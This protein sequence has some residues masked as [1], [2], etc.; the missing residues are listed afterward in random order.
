MKNPI[1]F[2]KKFQNPAF[3]LAFL[4]LTFT[5]TPLAISAK[6]D[7]P[8]KQVSQDFTKVAKE[9]IP[10]V[11]S[12]KV[13]YKP[14]QGTTNWQ[15]DSDNAPDVFGDDFLQNFFG[16]LGLTTPQPEIGQASG[17]IVSPD[18]YILT[19]SHVVKDAS[20]IIVTLNDGREFPAKVI[21]QDPN[22]DIA[23]VKINAKNLPHLK[24]GDSDDIEVGQWAIAIGNPFGLQATLTVGVI[25]AK[26]RNNLDLTPLENFIQT[27]AAINKGNSGGPLLNMDGQ[28]IGINTAIV[29]SLSTGYTGIGFA[30]PSNMAKVVMDQILTN[31]KVTRGYIGISLQQIDQGLAQAFNLEK[32][33]GVLVVEVSKNS[34]AEKAGLRQGD[35]ILKYNNHT[36][37]N[38]A[39]LRNAISLTAPGTKIILGILRNGKALEL[40]IEIGTF[41][42]QQQ[43]SATAAD[44]HLGV[45]VEN[46]TSEIASSMGIP[47]EK[48]VVISKI[49]QGSV[50]AWAG[51]K[52]GAI[53]LAVNQKKVSNIEEFKTALK[54]TPANKP[55]LFLIKQGD[56]MRFVSLKEG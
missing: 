6:E 9:A 53:I 18:G 38:I 36:V 22:T 40:P 1:S 55:V 32:T 20:E 35:I 52:K 26:G 4:S 21:G 8:A 49:D 44:N 10:A 19:N 30:I 23:V 39:Y 33:E 56:T 29:S 45:A 7:L 5:G 31:G 17:F 54:E 15:S 16:G 51:L 28:V 46:L 25:S 24:L 42:A 14:N 47:N 3:I 37:S 34:P 27:D 13:Q 48:G 50:A 41:P 12:L 11:V 2:T 43:V